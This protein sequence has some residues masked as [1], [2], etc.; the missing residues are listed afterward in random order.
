MCPFGGETSS[1]PQAAAVFDATLAAG[2]VGTRARDRDTFARFFSGLDP[3][4]SPLSPDGAHECVPQSGVRF[5]VP[6]AP[7]TQIDSCSSARTSS[8]CSGWMVAT[9]SR[10]G[11][12]RWAA[13]R[14]GVHG[15]P[16]WLI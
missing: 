10:I 15:H 13:E 6:G 16:C 1:N 11:P 5:P 9:M 8:S 7:C 4:T 12:T 14:I 2:H 3:E